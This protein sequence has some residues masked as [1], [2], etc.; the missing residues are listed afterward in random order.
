MSL[1]DKLKTGMKG[2]V[3]TISKNSSKNFVYR[4]IMVGL[5]AIIS[6]NYV[7]KESQHEKTFDAC[8]KYELVHN[9]TNTKNISATQ[10]TETTSDVNHKSTKS[11]SNENEKNI[12]K[13]KKEFNAIEIKASYDYNGAITNSRNDLEKCLEALDPP[14]KINFERVIITIP[15]I[16]NYKDFGKEIFRINESIDSILTQFYKKHGQIDIA[17]IEAHSSPRSM[18]LARP[19]TIIDKDS[20]SYFSIKSFDVNS[21]AIEFVAEQNKISKHI[22]SNDARVLIKGCSA[23][24]KISST[25]I[26]QA[27][28]NGYNVQTEAPE[29]IYTGDFVIYND[30][31]Q[32][33]S[34]K[35]K[36]VYFGEDIRDNIYRYKTQNDEEFIVDIQDTIILNK[37]V[38]IFYG[39]K[40]LKLLATK[41]GNTNNTTIENSCTLSDKEC[42]P[43]KLD[44]SKFPYENM[45]EIYKGI[46]LTG[47]PTGLPRQYHIVEV[48]SDFTD[49][50]DIAIYPR[51][52]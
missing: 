25:N 37:K 19:D 22:F 39:P 3:S 46:I 1:A 10:N 50:E 32:L 21:T 49:F 51:K 11:V 42:E 45:Y 2:V 43:N 14:K 13:R 44:H 28:R 12:F 5:L 47:D 8:A 23:G 38:D 41:Y 34:S 48:R 16:I 20:N 6:P 33:E 31:I 26:A 29:H 52:K 4:T 17:F 15:K 18:T 27:I 36:R 40:E 7:N 35:T 30:S 9:N 24:R